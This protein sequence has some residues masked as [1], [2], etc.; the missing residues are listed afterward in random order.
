[1]SGLGAVLSFSALHINGMAN[2]D[3]CFRQLSHQFYF[4]NMG[5]LVCPLCCDEEFSNQLSLRYHLLSITDNVYC[6][7][8]CQRFDSILQLAEH[9]DGMCGKAE[10]V[11]SIEEY[12]PDSDMVM[13]EGMTEEDKLIMHERNTCETEVVTEINN[14]GNM[15]SDVCEV[16]C[17]VTR[18]IHDIRFLYMHKLVIEQ[19][20][21]H[22]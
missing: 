21:F 6:P 10:L 18:D 8:C 9:L 17:S 22:T 1:M 12:T 19:F 5:T 20:K 3:L 16:R 11:N 14:P 15:S 13:A 7:E 4:A 2:V